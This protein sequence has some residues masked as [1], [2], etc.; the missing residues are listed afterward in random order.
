M[1]I[2]EICYFVAETAVGLSPASV[3]FSSV[4]RDFKIQFTIN[5]HKVSVHTVTLFY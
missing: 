1:T 4:H 2:K 3:Q 5:P